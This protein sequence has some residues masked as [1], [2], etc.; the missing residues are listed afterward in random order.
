M[1]DSTIQFTVNRSAVWAEVERDLARKV[2][3]ITRRIAAQAK[4]NTP[5]LT[6][7]LRRSIQEDPLQVAPFRITSGVTATADYAVFVHEGTRAHVIRAKNVKNLR[8]QMGGRTVFAPS[9]NHP[10]TRARP[11]LRNAAESVSKSL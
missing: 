2:A 9:V 7:N 11:F 3:S 6:G 4:E 5:V 8:F 1:A 10:G